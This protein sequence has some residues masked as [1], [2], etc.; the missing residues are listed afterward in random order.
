MKYAH[1]QSEIPQ[2]DVI[3][4]KTKTGEAQVK[5]AISKAVCYYLKY[6]NEEEEF[7]G[8]C[9]YDEFGK[10]KEGKYVHVQSVFPQ[11]DVIALKMKTGEAQVKDAISKAV[12]YYLKFGKENRILQ[13]SQTL[14]SCEDRIGD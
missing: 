2:E 9:G 4:L 14:G 8:Y 10:K 6:A 11:E 1:V 13:A 5:D 3:A 7:S 12:C